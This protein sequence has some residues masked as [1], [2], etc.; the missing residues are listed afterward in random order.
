[1]KEDSYSAPNKVLEI[2]SS[3]WF[4]LI[5]FFS[6]VDRW[7]N[8]IP[9][10]RRGLNRGYGAIRRHGP[11]PEPGQK[12]S[13]YTPPSRQRAQ[14]L[15]DQD[16][17]DDSTTSNDDTEMLSEESDDPGMAVEPVG[18]SPSS[19]VC[20]GIIRLLLTNLKELQEITYAKS[21]KVDTPKVFCK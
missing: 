20:K 15:P 14:R 16:D 6:S 7:Q 13:P 12:N 5:L 18:Q 4:H 11:P 8:F 2:R 9:Q 21:Y 17:E 10:V 3:G 19:Q 1:M